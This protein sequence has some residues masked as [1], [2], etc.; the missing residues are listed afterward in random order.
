[1]AELKKQST[2]KDED[3]ILTSV[4]IKLGYMTEED[5]TDIHNSGDYGIC[6]SQ[7]GKKEYYSALD[8]NNIDDEFH[9]TLNLPFKDF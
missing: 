3:L 2:T 7:D 4:K 1:M 9:I 5:K 8:P 6:I